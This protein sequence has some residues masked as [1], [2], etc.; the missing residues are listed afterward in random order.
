MR[1]I[2]GE[3]PGRLLLV[4]LGVLVAYAR[5]GAGVAVVAG[6]GR[7]VMSRPSAV[8][9]WGGLRWWR[10]PDDVGLLMERGRAAACVAGA[11]RPRVG[12]WASGTRDGEARER[13]ARVA[14]DG[15]GMGAGGYRGGELA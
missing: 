1:T 2:I 7:G 5:I 6:S 15:P 12:G 3:G 9:W 13:G 14:P 4:L 8:R 11:A 10:L